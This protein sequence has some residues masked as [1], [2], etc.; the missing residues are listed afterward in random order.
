MGVMDRRRR[1]RFSWHRKWMNSGE[2][3]QSMPT[4]LQ[5]NVTGVLK[6]TIDPRPAR[7]YRTNIKRACKISGW[8]IGESPCIL[9]TDERTEME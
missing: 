3:W 2:I 4:D 7:S 8:G 6:R 5:D 9:G 1:I